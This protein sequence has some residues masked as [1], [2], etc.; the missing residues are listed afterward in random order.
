MEY[1]KLFLSK[2]IQDEDI[3][4][5]NLYNI[6][7]SDM[8]TKADAETMRYLLRYSEENNG[9]VPSYAS[10]AIEVDEFEYVPDVTNNFEHL[11]KK[12]KEFSAQKELLGWFR[13][14]EGKYSKFE[15]ALNEMGADKFLKTWLPTQIDN[16]LTNNGVRE[17]IGTS[18][19]DDGEAFLAE[20]MRRK[21]GESF[22]VWKSKFPCI[23]EY[24][25]SNLYTVYGKSG[26][27]KSVI[28]LEDG[29]YAA[30]QGANVLLWALEMGM[31]EVLVR[32]YVSISGNKGVEKALINGYSMDSGFNSHDIRYGA[33][34]EEYEES[35]QSFVRSMNDI[36][37][38]NIIVRAVD[39]ADFSD[40]TVRALEADIKASNADYVIIDPFYYMDYEKNT[41]KTTGGDAIQTSNRL[42]RLAG[43]SQTVI[44]AI[45]QADES[46]EEEDED[47][48]RELELPTRGEV[49]KTFSLLEDAYLL[50]AVDTDYKQGRG[51]VGVNKG[52]DG[53][54]GNTSEILYIPNHGIVKYAET[55][56]GRE[57][58]FVF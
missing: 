15:E 42:R 55:G 51:L 4:P 33:L 34:N 22:K 1:A 45:T 2:V 41:S 46:S 30:I 37:E 53:G 9:Q 54:E 57:G 18:V 10:V 58:E 39:D 25:S 12:I 11:A 31:Y 5:I 23:G 17:K 19:K 24:V 44:V 35:F 27:G 13:K 49:K 29:V 28:T 43:S 32:I 50:I 38:G 8:P 7:I 3:S 36:L 21:E 16:V 48:F 14:E 40:R 6:K 56:E 20:Y 52:R 26:R 47:G